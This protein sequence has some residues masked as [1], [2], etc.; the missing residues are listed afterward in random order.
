MSLTKLSLDGNNRDGKI[1]NLFYSVELLY[2]KTE[3]QEDR[4]PGRK[5]KR[6]DG[7]V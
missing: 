6:K 5:R 4:N 7:T 2:M 3:K 1:A